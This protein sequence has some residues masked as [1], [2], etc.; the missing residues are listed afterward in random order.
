MDLAAAIT[1]GRRLFMIQLLA[2]LIF[3]APIIASA[4]LA[5][6]RGRG[7][8]GRWLFLIVGPL[9]VYT[10]IWLAM[11]IFMVPAWFVLTWFTPALHEIL[12]T[13]PFW[14]PVFA[15]VAKHDGYI[16]SV[17]S[18]ALTFWLVGHFWPR[19][20]AILAALTSPSSSKSLGAK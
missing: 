12:H 19:W 15:W 18:L 8:R 10:V 16:A 2:V 6:V 5:C 1:E 9:I 3:F 20:P 4:F 17:I 7:V 13:K 11:L 14:F